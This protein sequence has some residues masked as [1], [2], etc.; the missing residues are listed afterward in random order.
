MMGVLAGALGV[1][2]ATLDPA[3]PVVIQN[4]PANEALIAQAKA[5][6]RTVI[7]PSATESTEH[8]YSHEAALLATARAVLEH[9]GVGVAA[10]EQVAHYLGGG[11]RV[12]AIGQGRRMVDLLSAN[13]VAS[14]RTLMAEWCGRHGVD[15]RKARLMFHHRV[16]R[17]ERLA[18]F[19]PLLE[20]HPS[21]IIGDRPQPSLVAGLRVDWVPTLD[22]RRLPT[23]AVSFLVGNASGLGSETRGDL[24][25][26][27][28]ALLRETGGA[29][30]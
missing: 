18:S 16:D 2:L 30:C 17:P 24:A 15:E 29:P 5:Q 26:L 10:R 23:E 21:T 3:V 19:R 8:L 25:R 27:H 9:L 14:T 28:H 12:F 20:R 1:V 6:F 13:D 22:M 4:V 11:P 7:V